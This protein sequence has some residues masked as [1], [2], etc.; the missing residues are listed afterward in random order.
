MAK[1][2]DFVAFDAVGK[3]SNC[4]VLCRIRAPVVDVEARGYDNEIFF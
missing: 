1:I 4:F 2:L 3:T